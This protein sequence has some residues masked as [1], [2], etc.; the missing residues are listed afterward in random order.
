MTLAIWLHE[1]HSFKTFG[2]RPA[3]ARKP[4][5][6]CHQESRPKFTCTVAA[7]YK[8]SL[9][10]GTFLGISSVPL[11]VIHASTD[12]HLFDVLS[13]TM[14]NEFI[15]QIGLPQC[16]S[17]VCCHISNWLSNMS[18]SWYIKHISPTCLSILNISMCIISSPIPKP[19]FE[20]PS[21]VKARNEYVEKNCQC[22]FNKVVFVE[23]VRHKQLC[24]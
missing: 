3:V 9:Q 14:N 4:V 17:L 8:R 18:L 2:S 6:S 20:H 22:V 10:K 13:A 15:P 21:A 7:H 16:L 24:C 12:A 5:P 19:I 11:Q 23:L 1:G